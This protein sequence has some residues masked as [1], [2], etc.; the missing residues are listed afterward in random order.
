MG[1]GHP[2]R[3]YFATYL[4]QK[5]PFGGMIGV[6]LSPF[7]MIKIADY[8]NGFCIAIRKWI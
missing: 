6:N 8:C 2:N 4:W 5:H 1:I 7:V 3:D